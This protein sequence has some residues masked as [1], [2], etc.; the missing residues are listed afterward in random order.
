METLN[1]PDIL[2]ATLNARYIHASLGLRYLYANL[3]AYQC[4]TKIAEFVITQ[5]PID[6]A[7]AI[8]ARAPRIVGFGVYIW[9]VEETAK[10]I[11][12]LKAV[13]PDV[14]IVLGGPEV[15]YEHDQQPIVA[16]ADYVITGWGDLSFA[17]LCARL[18]DHSPPAG[19][20]I[21]GEQPPLND[22]VLP[23]R[24][25]TDEDIARRLV[26][27]EASRG[28]PFK[29]EFCLS[30]LD[31]T[32]WPFDLDRFLL[33]IQSLHERGARHF[34]FVD[35]TF[36]L[37]IKTSERILAFFLERLDARLF[38]HFELIPDHLPDPLKAMIQ[39]FP[40][41]QLQFEIGIQSWNPAV[42][43]LISRRQDNDRSAANI[44]WLRDHTG[45]HL[46]TDLIVGLPGE[47]LES[48]GEGFDR[49]VAL[50]PHEIQV[51]ILKRLRGTPI[52]RHTEPFSMQYS[53]HPPYNIL[54][55]ALIDFPTMQRLQRFARYWDLVGNSGRFVHTLPHLLGTQPF[56]RFM[57]FADWLFARTGQTHAIALDRLFDL[58]YAA[59]TELFQIA[60]EHARAPLAMDYTA[61]GARGAPM[62]LRGEA[63]PT[64]GSSAGGSRQNSHG[65]GAARQARHQ[66]A[67]TFQ[68]SES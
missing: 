57:R 18:L 11:A 40:P 12:V 30:S 64:N 65:S 27:V 68:T 24:Y 25:Y 17:R 47:T 58:V 63:G 59:L 8:L 62:F 50:G 61:S 41:G 33:E 51:G 60:G 21:V 67:V 16:L 3:G 66:R 10:V 56:E 4:R 43:S 53:P 5:R 9:N 52:A 45:A 37:N 2:L 42:Q 7:E 35:R 6:I 1:T 46:H 39:R 19:K 44:R 13:C 49:M 26:Y 48:F 31:K 15:S 14:R 23:Y 20:I 55:N 38:L 54:A 32:A 36:N 28:C 22:I 29:C 34:K